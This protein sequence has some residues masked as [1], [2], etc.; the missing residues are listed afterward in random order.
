VAL[1]NM[2]P[3]I[4]NG[5]IVELGEINCPS[6]IAVIV[7]MGY[8]RFWS[9]RRDPVPHVEEFTDPKTKAKIASSAD[10]F[11]AGKDAVAVARLADFQSF[12]FIYDLPSDGAETIGGKIA[13]LAS[14]HGLDA[15]LEREPRRIPHRERAQRA[16]DLGGGDFI[17]EGPWVGVIGTL[18]N[19]PLIVRGRRQDYGGNVGSRWAEVSIEVSRAHVAAS[20]QI[21]YVGVDHGL[22]LLGDAE[23]VGSWQHFEP[24]DGLYDVAFWGVVG[25]PLSGDLGAPPLN[26]GWGWRDLGKDEAHGRMQQVRSWLGPDGPEGRLGLELRPHSHFYRVMEQIRSGSLEVGALALDGAKL[27]GLSTSWGDG[28]F[29]IWVERGASGAVVAIRLELGSEK[30]RRLMEAVWARAEDSGQ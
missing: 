25:E 22:I 15:R 9:G 18:P 16:A 28:L 10:Y 20:V 23:A 6:G 14:E 5:G 7:D 4:A 13:R 26:E 24:L 1:K 21:G 3:Q 8:M 27:L 2:N 12:H 11:I 30:R 17:M 29:P 19:T